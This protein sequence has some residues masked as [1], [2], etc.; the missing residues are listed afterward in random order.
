MPAAIATRGLR[1]RG[2]C[3]KLLAEDLALGVEVSAVAADAA[4]VELDGVVGD[5]GPDVE[6]LE[7]PIAR[8]TWSACGPALEAAPLPGPGLFGPRPGRRCVGLW[9]LAGGAALRSPFGV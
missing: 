4:D 7:G 3:G 2:S 1:R 9:R 5:Q 6:Q 8:G